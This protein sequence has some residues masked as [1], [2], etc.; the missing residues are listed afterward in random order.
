M[1]A[2]RKH[3]P[4]SIQNRGFSPIPNDRFRGNVLRPKAAA[5]DASFIHAVRVR[6]DVQDD[7]RR[8]DRKRPIDASQDGSN[9]GRSAVAP[10]IVARS[11]W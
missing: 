11:R 5:D 2:G 10:T 1:H 8:M 3:V 6:R 7:R 4:A 9:C